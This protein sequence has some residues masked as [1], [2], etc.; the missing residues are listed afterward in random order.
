MN[1]IKKT[2]DTV[3]AE[4]KT[5][6]IIDQESYEAGAEFLKKI[7]ATTKIVEAEY[8][9]EKKATYDA[10]KEVLAEI[11]A[12]TDP[13]SEAEKTIKGIMQKYVAAET[14][15]KEEAAEKA[16][17][18]IEEDRL[19]KAIATGDESRLERPI[20]LGKGFTAPPK[21]AG[22]YTV[23]T[24]KYEITDPA[25]INSE[26]MIPDEAAIRRT[27]QTMKD[28]AQSLVGEGV[29]VYCEREIRVRA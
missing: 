4:M 1:D 18:M 28:K 17:R 22:T 9:Y 27:V 16:R 26:F 23:D 12:F 5:I 24:W 25:K 3:L 2:V 7:K 29:R 11:K 15:R 10:Y 21:A 20:D 13:L 6:T 8:E 14:K 19:E